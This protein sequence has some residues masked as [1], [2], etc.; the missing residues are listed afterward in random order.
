MTAT[1]LALTVHGAAVLAFSCA[2]RRLTG[3]LLDRPSVSDP[4]FCGSVSDRAARSFPSAALD[5]LSGPPRAL[6]RVD[7]RDMA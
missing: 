3:D 7:V 4:C 6:E 1:P 2:G 5:R